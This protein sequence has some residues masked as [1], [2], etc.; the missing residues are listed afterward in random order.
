[1]EGDPKDFAY[2]SVTKQYFWD[3]D[4]A[5]DITVNIPYSQR[6]IEDV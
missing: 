5:K 6:V 1:M 3:P 4:L 2:S